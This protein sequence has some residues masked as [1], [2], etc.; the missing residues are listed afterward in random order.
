MVPEASGYNQRPELIRNKKNIIRLFDAQKDT[1]ASLVEQADCF[2]A[3]ARENVTSNAEHSKANVLS[4][5]M[6]NRPVFN[7]SN[8]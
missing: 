3:T 7:N 6:N 4:L 5:I 1:V 8:N 2:I